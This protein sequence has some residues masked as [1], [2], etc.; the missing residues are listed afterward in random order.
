MLDSNRVFGGTGEPHIFINR[1]VW[2]KGLV[3]P[4]YSKGCNCRSW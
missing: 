4:A 3:V 1:D 2:D